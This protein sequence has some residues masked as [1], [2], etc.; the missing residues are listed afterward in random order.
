MLRAQAMGDGVAVTIQPAVGTELL[1]A[2]ALWH[3]LTPKER[4]VVEQVIE[5]LAAE[6][7]ARRLAI[8]P[9]TVHDH[10]KPISRELGVSAREELI[11]RL[12]G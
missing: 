12:I 1:A 3:G 4:A 5:G 7:I 6:Q 10:F 9:H 8:S 11:A 2:I